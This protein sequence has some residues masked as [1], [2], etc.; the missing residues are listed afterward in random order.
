[1]TYGISR[2]KIRP[3]T[4]VW[5]HDG[6][7]TYV[8]YIE[9]RNRKTVNVL[10]DD[11]ASPVGY[12]VWRIS[13]SFISSSPSEAEERWRDYAWRLNEFKRV[14]G[15]RRGLY[16]YQRGMGVLVEPSN[17]PLY[18]GM[19][20]RVG[21]ITLTVVTEDGRLMKVD[22]AY[23][24]PIHEPIRINLGG[25]GLEGEVSNRAVSQTNRTGIRQG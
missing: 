24:T 17:R 1:M 10:V 6:D 4:K 7:K 16:R 22:K 18:K 8:G 21:R 11:Q 20:S 14:V 19:V 12:T 25:I 2:L 23:C 9:R 13:E 15:K 5:F 3:G